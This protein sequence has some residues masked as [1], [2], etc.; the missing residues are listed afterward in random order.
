MGFEEQMRQDHAATTMGAG[1]LLMFEVE[2]SSGDLYS[3]EVSRGARGPLIDCNCQAGQNGQYC[4][5]RFALLDG[6]TSRLLAGHDDI[7]ALLTMVE[8]TEL[9]AAIGRMRQLEAEAAKL[10]AELSKAK[11]AVARAMMDG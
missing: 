9:S 8:N 11:K 3:I 10:K 5:H 2:G 4:K 6:D 1:M 7:P